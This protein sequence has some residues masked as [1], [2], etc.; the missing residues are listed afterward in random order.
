M[1]LKFLETILDAMQIDVT[2]KSMEFATNSRL[3]N[4][5]RILRPLKSTQTSI[6]VTN[7]SL[8]KVNARKD[9]EETL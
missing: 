9:I 8:G 7:A 6:T 1:M 4:K 2:Q 3:A 5:R